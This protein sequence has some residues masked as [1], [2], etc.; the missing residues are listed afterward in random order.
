MD[1]NMRM[2]RRALITCCAAALFAAGCGSSAPSNREKVFP[3]KGKVVYK[4]KPVT[5]ADITFICKEKDRGAFGR[6]DGDGVFQLTTFSSNDGA[7]AGKHTVVVTKVEVAAPAKQEAPIDSPDYVPP[8][9]MGRVAPPKPQIPPKYSDA[10]TS[11][12]IAI[13]N[14]DGNNAEITLELKD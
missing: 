13:V 12:L 7:V 9:P 8:Q 11:D 10:K 3:V 1:L 2:P 5:N 6:T 4:G 14:D